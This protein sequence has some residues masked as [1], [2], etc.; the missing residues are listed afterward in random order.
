MY[1]SVTIPEELIEWAKSLQE[2]YETK[3]ENG[4]DVTYYSFADSAKDFIDKF[5]EECDM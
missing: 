3:L 2:D 5:L 4:E 1:K